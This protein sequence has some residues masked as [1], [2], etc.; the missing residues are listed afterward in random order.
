M[1]L[2][3]I[4]VSI[5]I[6]GFIIFFH[7]LGHFILAKKNDVKVNE[8]NIGMG[9]AIISHTKGETTYA[10]RILPFGGSCVMEG[11]DTSSDDPRAFP[12]KTVWQRIAIVF[13]GPFFNFILAFLLSLILLGSIGVD[14]PVIAEITEGYPAQ[15]AGLQAGDEITRIGNY[16]IH[17][18]NEVS[19]Y[20]FFHTGQPL[21]ITYKRGDEKHEATI[22]PKY[23]EESGR[24]LI[25][26]VTDGKRTRVNAIDT[27]KYSFY[28]IR[29]QIYSVLSG[30][31]YLVTGRIGLKD[32]SGTVGIMK[33]IGDNYTEASNYGVF[34]TVMQMINIAI[35]L[36]ANLGVMNLLPLPALDG[37]RLL[38]FIIEAIRG[39]R[40]NE[41]IENGINYV[42][43]IL[44]MALM[45]V[46]MVSD[47]YKL[48]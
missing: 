44:L 23:D 34:V 7:E 29:Y 1:S 10:L 14:R 39:K 47:I 4:I 45:V 18:Y 11:E 12:T 2:A 3:S 41:K 24:Y 43:F 35:L 30:L 33:V 25:G 22:L 38:I 5:L 48:M 9:P 46:I 16:N 27:V 8:F 26:I 37:G 21:D 17:F 6:F 28:E 19:L 36:T 31:R 40:M 20:V 32:M 15:A 42:G 13:A